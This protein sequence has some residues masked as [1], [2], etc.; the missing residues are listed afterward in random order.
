MNDINRQSPVSN[1]DFQ[2]SAV[3]TREAGVQAVEIAAKTAINKSNY[4]FGKIVQ[5]IPEECYGDKCEE[6]EFTLVQDEHLSGINFGNDIKVLCIP[7]I[8]Y[9]IMC[10]F[11]GATSVNQVESTPYTNVPLISLLL[12][13]TLPA[14]MKEKGYIYSGEL[15]FDDR[16]NF[17]PC[18]KTIWLVRGNEV[19]FTTGG[20][21]YFSRGDDRVVFYN[22]FNK[23]RAASGITCY[24]KNGNHSKQIIKD[25][26]DYTYGRNCLRGIKIRGVNMYRATFDEVTPDKKYSWNNYYYDDDIINLFDLEVFGFLKNL[27]EYK[28]VGIHKRGI[29]TWGSAGTGKTTLGHIICN[30]A[31]DYTVMWI[32]P[33]MIGMDSSQGDSLMVLYKLAE[34]VSPSIVILEDLDL[35]GEDRSSSHNN[36]RL[37]VL[38]NIM[39][40]VH[41]VKDSITIGTTNR[42]GSIEKALR[43]RP[44]RFDRI[45][46]IPSL[47]DDLRKRMIQDRTLDYKI[48]NSVIDDMVRKTEGWTG[49][50][51]QE[52]INTIGLHFLDKKMKIKKITIDVVDEVLST[53]RK[54]GVGEKS[55]MFGFNKD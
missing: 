50:E 22:Y 54:F 53:M 9:R 4:T 19:C 20:F 27:K 35:Y 3:G 30:L 48:A 15:N 44:G 31:E 49:A 40:G 2:Q 37:G 46:E 6:N 51:I 38:M 10:Y 23:D 8:D 36:S 21:S 26:E 39:D 17:I 32:T 41:S 18:S 43:N 33:D 11:L 45:V 25:L 34:F 42:L 28:A 12:M 47:K 52:L 13:Q 5:K 14:F 7:V 55:G 16:G 29:I 24:T 1:L